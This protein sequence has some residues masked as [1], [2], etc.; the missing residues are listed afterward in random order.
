[1]NLARL[2][3]GAAGGVGPVTFVVGHSGEFMMNSPFF[4]ERT[5]T[6][7]WMV[8]GATLTSNSSRSALAIR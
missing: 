4:F 5:L 3:P 7:L 1:L 2:V 8:L 6:K